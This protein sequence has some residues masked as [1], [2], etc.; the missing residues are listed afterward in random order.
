MRV[1]DERRPEHGLGT[2]VEGADRNPPLLASVV[3]F[4]NEQPRGATVV[5]KKWIGKV[6]ASRR[7][8]PSKAS[9]VERLTPSCRL[10]EKAASLANRYA[11]VLYGIEVQGSPGADRPRLEKGTNHLNEE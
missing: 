10:V 7:F 6:P 4:F 1:T 5:E 8:E 11:P 3:V 9:G 2:V